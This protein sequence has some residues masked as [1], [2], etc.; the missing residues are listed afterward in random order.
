MTPAPP[1]QVP[2]DELVGR[3]EAAIDRLADGRAPVDQLV[4]TYEEATRL[5]SEGQARLD[6]IR[7]RIAPT[8]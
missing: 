2:L 6:E 8:G 5:L 1:A 7:E 3:L 4:S